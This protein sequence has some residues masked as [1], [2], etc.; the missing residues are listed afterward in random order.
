MCKILVKNVCSQ[1]FQFTKTESMRDRCPIAQTHCAQ[2]PQENYTLP[3]AM[4]LNKQ[5][6]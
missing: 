6:T 3:F 5:A 2:E 1:T 4:I